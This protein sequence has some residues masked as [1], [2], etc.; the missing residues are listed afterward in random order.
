MDAARGNI[1][2]VAARAL[3]GGL[4]L[5][6]A[7]AILAAIMMAIW[8]A[9]VI[10]LSCGS[11]AR[12]QSFEA[13]SAKAEKAQK[14]GQAPEALEY[15]T[16]ALRVWSPDKGKA[17]RAR[18]LAARAELESKAGD[19]D[20]ALKDLDESLQLDKKSAKTFDQRGQLH[21]A[22]GDTKKALADFYAATKLNLDFGLA[23]FHRGQAYARQDDSEFAR[24][25][26]RTACRLGVKEACAAAKKIVVKKRAPVAIPP[27]LARTPGEVSAAS[28]AAPSP[29]AAPAP[30]PAETD[31]EAPPQAEPAPAPAPAPKPKA[32]APSWRGK[33]IKPAEPAAAGFGR[34]D[35]DACRAAVDSCN[36]EGNAIDVCLKRVKVCTV[37]P[38]KGCCPRACL[39]D[40]DRRASADT[41]DA[42]LFRQI[43]GEHGDCRR[44][45]GA[46]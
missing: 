9:L 15:W 44:L 13:W 2:L 45:I 11:P 38:S 21:L 10:S 24:E 35:L 25:D 23:Y 14:K 41:S 46:H 22:K 36:E 17:R 3:S 40:F 30:A 42:E 34:V 4:T 37:K 26:Y 7:G 20:S 43:F 1:F 16:Q 27:E 12:A 28:A 6:A 5:A 19:P 8:T 18:A 31:A 39:Q 29:P 32:A 33:T